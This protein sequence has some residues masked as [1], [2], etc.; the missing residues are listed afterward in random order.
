MNYLDAK[1][2]SFYLH[3]ICF[4]CLALQQNHVRKL[5][6][7]KFISGYYCTSGVDRPMPG[8]SNDTNAANC[9][10]PLSV[11]HTGVGGICPIG[12][13]CPTGTDIPKGCNAGSYTDLEGQSVCT[14][15]PAG[16]YCLTNATEFLSTPCPVGKYLFNICSGM[17]RDIIWKARVRFFSRESETLFQIIFMFLRFFK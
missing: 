6:L 9:S 11:Y 2:I 1:W 10:C 13:Y 14:T 3:L 8:A 4:N 7:K 12:H 5:N 15:C 17:Q 16:F